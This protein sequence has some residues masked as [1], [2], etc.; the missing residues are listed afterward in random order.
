MMNESVL[1]VYMLC[2]VDTSPP[3]NRFILVVGVVVA[4]LLYVPVEDEL[5]GACR[6]GNIVIYSSY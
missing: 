2:S 6:D 3:M 1:N 5:I 4:E